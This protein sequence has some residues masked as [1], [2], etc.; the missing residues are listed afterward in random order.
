MSAV[1]GVVVPKIALYVLMMVF[2]MV[3]CVA[4]GIFRKMRGGMFLP[5]R[6]PTDDSPQS[7]AEMSAIRRAERLKK[8]NRS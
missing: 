7:L 3:L 5:A 4:V 8:K 1:V 6:H 2:I